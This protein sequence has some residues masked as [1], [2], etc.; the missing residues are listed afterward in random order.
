[1]VLFQS[2]F[3]KLN[4][5]LLAIILVYHLWHVCQWFTISGLGCSINDKYTYKFFLFC[6]LSTD[7]LHASTSKFYILSSYMSS[8]HFMEK[9]I[10]TQYMNE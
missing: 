9:D 3:L 6:N 1:M 8:N 10:L 2:N 4:L 7:F 5:V